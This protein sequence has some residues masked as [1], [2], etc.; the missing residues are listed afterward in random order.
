MRKPEI[1][2][3]GGQ[4]ILYMD[5]TGLREVSEIEQ[6]IKESKDYIRMQPEKSVITLSHIKG[7]HFNA[8]IKAIFSEFIGGNK[9]YV[10]HGAVVGLSGLQRIVY[11]GI[12]KLSG[13]ELRSF[14]TVDMAK[15]WLV[16]KDAVEA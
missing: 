7:M 12:M 14:E 10:S 15:D 1:I 16:S 5:F 2:N 9:A 3:H 6:L 4:R 13:R 8:E 11:N